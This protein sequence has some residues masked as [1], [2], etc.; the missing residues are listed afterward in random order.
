MV[1]S[2]EQATELVTNV[3]RAAEVS[4]CGT[5]HHQVDPKG[6]VAVPAQLRRGLP[7]GSVVSPAPDHRLMIW[8]PSAWT[9]QQELYRRTAETAEQERRFLRAL[10]GNAYPLEVDGQGRMLLA[11]QQR[12]WAGIDNRAVF[13]GL[14]AG[15]E[16]AAET[17]W[18]EQQGELV[19]EDFTRLHDLVYQRAQGSPEPA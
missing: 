5:Y 15:I 4:F 2:G 17:T 10:V 7:D 8:P 12:S 14:G 18:A 9:A 19:P 6:R 3:D 1:N 13:V 16:I 11:P